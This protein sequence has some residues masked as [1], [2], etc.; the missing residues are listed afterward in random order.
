MNSTTHTLCIYTLFV[1]RTKLIARARIYYCDK[2]AEPRLLGA[3]KAK[4]VA[5]VA[6][7]KMSSSCSSSSEEEQVDPERRLRGNN[8]SSSLYST[9]TSPA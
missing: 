3:E 6:K 7:R 1:K 5:S 2:L 4:A 8:V 9:K